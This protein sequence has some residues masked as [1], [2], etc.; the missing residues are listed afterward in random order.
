MDNYQ[1]ELFVI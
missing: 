1:N